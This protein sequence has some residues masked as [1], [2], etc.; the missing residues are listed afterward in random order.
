M[1]NEYGAGLRDLIA[2]EFSVETVIEMHDVDAFEDAVSAYPASVVI[3]NA[4]QA[5]S[6]VA[7]ADAEFDANA[8]TAFERWTRRGRS[9][10]FRRTGCVA[11]RL[12]EWFDG[13]S[14]WPAGNPDALA[15]IA[16]LERRFA[17][18]EDPST[19]TRV[20]IGVATGADSVFITRD[21]GLVESERLLPLVSTGDVASGTVEW[22][23]RYLVNPWNSDGLVNLDAFPRLRAYYEANG[24]RLRSRHVAVKRPDNWFRTIDRV[25]PNLLSRPKL[26]LPDIKAASHPVLDSGSLY[27]H[28]N[29]YFVVSDVWDL[30]VLGGLLL[31]DVANLFVG[32]YC[33]KMRGGCFRFQAQ[34]IR[35]IRLPR[36]TDLSKKQAHAL[37]AA[38]RTRD[39]A[40]AT[41]AAVEVYGIVDLPTLH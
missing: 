11:T 3:R 4:A 7:Q 13:D 9:A 1:H 23:G 14:L 18:L 21:A 34:Y 16:E 30:E 28:H 27:P 20:G 38:F 12:P 39:V 36:P 40:A 10:S 31:S 33:V 2:R 35:R 5:K 17:P 6:V 37:R 41:A 24:A 29:L 15:L 32:A 26:L 25:D 19:G 22:S 8:A